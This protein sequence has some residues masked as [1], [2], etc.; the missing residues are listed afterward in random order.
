[1]K[2]FNIH[3][4]KVGALIFLIFS[5]AYGIVASRIPMMFYAEEGAFTPRTMPYAL[6]ACGIVVSLAMLI[7]PT[8]SEDEEKDHSL[9]GAFKGLEWKQ[10]GQ[11]AVVMILYGLT[12]KV[13]GFLVSTFVFLM[14]GFWI[15]GERR[16]KVLLL[17]SIPLV[18]GFWLIMTKLL[19][20]YL[21][22]GSLF[23]Y[24]GGSS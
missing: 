18:V 24:L 11:L 23:F 15:L 12:L 4:E 17:V 9:A 21:D 20:V 8:V 16:I 1:M 19:E 7:L 6:C 2:L 22:P 14:A 5:T 10:V 3:R 13:V